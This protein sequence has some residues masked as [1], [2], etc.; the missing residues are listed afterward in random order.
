L[1][2]KRGWIKLSVNFNLAVVAHACNPNY[3]GGRYQEDH[4]LR[5]GFFFSKKILTEKGLVEW[6]MV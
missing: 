1:W 4:G 3:S 6:L 5:P 2:G